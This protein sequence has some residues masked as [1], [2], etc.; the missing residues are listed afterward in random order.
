MKAKVT[1]LIILALLLAAEIGLLV[2]M[3]NAEPEIT[4][5]ATEAFVTE[6][7]ETLPTEV[8]TEPVE[9]IPP[10]ETDVPTLPPETEH[11]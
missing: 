7:V 3:D 6:A 4:M 2:V 5:Q 11:P 10:T 1:I 8:V 9:T